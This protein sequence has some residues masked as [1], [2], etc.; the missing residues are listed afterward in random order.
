[1]SNIYT[2]IRKIHGG[3]NDNGTMYFNNI[4]HGV[5]MTRKGAEK[6][7]KQVLN[8]TTKGFVEIWEYNEN[9]RCTLEIVYGGV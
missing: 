8:N 3:R 6:K 1:M 9:S 7:A 4:Q 5:Y 2:V